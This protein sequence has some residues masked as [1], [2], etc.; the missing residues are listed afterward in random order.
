MKLIKYGILLILCALCVESCERGEEQPHYSRAVIY[1]LKDPLW[2]VIC[3]LGNPSLEQ[4]VYSP[5][6]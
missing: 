2:G 5:I 4:V 6:P 1:T 3:F